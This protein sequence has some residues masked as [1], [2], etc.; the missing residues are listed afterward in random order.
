MVLRARPHLVCKCV[1]SM[2]AWCREQ[3]Q[4]RSDPLQALFNR[5]DSNGDGLLDRQEF[6]AMLRTTGQE[7]DAARLVELLDKPVNF[8]GFRPLLASLHVSAGTPPVHARGSPPAA[9]GGSSADSAPVTPRGRV[10][11]SAVKR[12]RAWSEKRK[13]LHAARQPGQDW[14]HQSSGLSFSSS[15]EAPGRQ[16][17][18]GNNG[19]VDLDSPHLALSPVGKAVQGAGRGKAGAALHAYATALH[20]EGIAQQASGGG[21]KCCA[22]SLSP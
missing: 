12:A 17:P 16:S 7:I 9:H 15:S 2:P 20:L 18:V 8:A 4:P 13:A 19:L 10:N 6:E 21:R 3:V 22:A 1:T 14:W 5:W 11:K